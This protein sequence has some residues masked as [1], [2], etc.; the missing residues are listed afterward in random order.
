M[1]SDDAVAAAALG[2]RRLSTTT[3]NFDYR[4]LWLWLMTVAEADEVINVGLVGGSMQMQM[5]HHGWLVG[6]GG[7]AASDADDARDGW[8]RETAVTARLYVSPPEESLPPKR[9]IS[10]QKKDSPA[11]KQKAFPSADA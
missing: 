5:L 1:I 11:K 10:R 7:L 9:T 2:E 4:R 3:S 6:V 8:R